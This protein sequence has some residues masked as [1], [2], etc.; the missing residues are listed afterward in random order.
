[1]QIIIILLNELLVIN[2]RSDG[3]YVWTLLAFCLRD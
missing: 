1:M 2:L 3:K